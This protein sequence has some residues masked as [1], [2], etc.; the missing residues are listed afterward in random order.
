[1]PE[2]KRGMKVLVACE[3]SGTVRD[4][5]RAK[6]HD[7][8]SCDI[9]PCE[10]H[11]RYHLQCDVFEAIESQHWDLMIA[12]PPC[13][14]LCSSGLHWNKKDPGR[15]EKTISALKFFMSLFD[16]GIDKV[17]VENPVGRAGTGFKKATQYIQPYEFGHD[18]SKKTGLWLRNLNPLK[19]TK[20]ISPRY[21]CCGESFDYGL[22]KYGCLYCN[23]N[24]KPKQRWSNQTDGGQNKLGPSEDRW[25]MRSKTYEGIAAAMA[26]QWGGDA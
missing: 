4:A 22:G 25:K 24:N 21:V 17:A 19:P 13:T 14:Y 1:M 23:G 8:W 6:G 12:H 15:E 11:E 3:F 26:D 18:A 20:F 7:A 9:L 16:C 5:F 2:F 10:D